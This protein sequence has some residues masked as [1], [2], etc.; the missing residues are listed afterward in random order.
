MMQLIVQDID[1]AFE[2]ISA[3]ELF[4]VKHSSIEQ[5]SWG[6]VIYLWGPSGEL[7]HF[8]ELSSAC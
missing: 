8:T 7:W 2:S 6:K 4:E 1:K 3:I 5:E